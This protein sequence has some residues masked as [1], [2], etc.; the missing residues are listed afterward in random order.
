MEE[1]AQL[2]KTL[3]PQWVW[4][5]ALG[6]AVGWGSFVLPTEWIATAGPLGAVLGL[7]I[8][9]ALMIVIAVSY[10]FLIREVPVSGGEFA[11]AY[12]G[13]G[14]THAY[15][16]GWFLALGYFSIVALNASALG[17]LAKFTAPALV[18]W[19]RMY[20]IAGWDVHLGEVLITTVALVL[21][22]VLNVRGSTVSG[23]V[24]FVFV[25]TMIVGAVLL[26]IGVLVHPGTT[27]SNALPWFAPDIPPWSAVLAIVA[28]APWAYVGF[29]NVPQAAEEF[30]FAPSK[31]FRLIVFALLAA[32]LFYSMMVLATAVA[33][34]WRSLVASNAA[35][36]TADAVAG[37]FGAL[38]I[39]VLSVA[40]CMGI[41]TGLNGFYVAASR[42][43][44]S[45]GRARILPS[46]FGRVHPRFNTPA[47]G[48]IF[49]A[50]VCLI[51]PWFGRQALLWIVDMSAAGVAIAYTYTCVV[52]YRL[53]QWRST[54]AAAT[55]RIPTTPAVAPV[56]KFLSLLGTLL[57]ITFLGLLLLPIS[58]AAL[59]LPSWVALIAWTVLGVAFYLVRAR[60]IQQIPDQEMDHLILDANAPDDGPSV[61]EPRI[62][63]GG[64]ERSTTA[65][66]A[67]VETGTADPPP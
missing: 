55:A 13:F 33:M 60:T 61:P 4:A 12:L 24:Q 22:A 62:E 20:E 46:F 21:F 48:I 25:L 58:P 10:G 49:T 27:L 11:Y 9:G 66:P 36:G 28:I 8:G 31:A 18:E 57:G 6:S 50:V 30:N 37:L 41:F 67:P 43:M 65:S 7:L 51:T 53:F 45:M 5:I 35:W 34:P 19:G 42:L 1:R 14:R 16:C 23:K 56:K 47:A 54:G 39:L 29:D 32:A 2:S 40:L 3:R 52:A 64:A 44:F 59:S 15:A 38:G 17:V 26:A 63:R